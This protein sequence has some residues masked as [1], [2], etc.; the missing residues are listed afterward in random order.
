MKIKLLTHCDL[1]GY[2]CQVLA[3]LAFGENVEVW[4]C[5]YHNIDKSV[6]KS[7]DDDSY[8]ELHITDISCSMFVASQ[9]NNAK[10]KPTYLMDHH[11]TA[12]SL[13]KFDWCQVETNN[14]QGLLT[15]GTELYYHFLKEKGYLQTDETLGK[16]IE[17]FVEIVRDYDTWRWFELKKVQ[18][19]QLND[20]VGLYGP[21]KFV[22]W[23]LRKINDGSFPEFDETDKLVLSIRQDE[24]DAYVRVKEKQMVERE[25]LE[26]KC[27]IVFAERFFDEVGNKICSNNPE[28]DLIIMVDMAK[29]K[30]SY[31]T[32]KDDVNVAEFA[33]MI[34]YGGGHPKAAGSQ[35][36]EDY[37]NLFLNNILSEN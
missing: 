16:T 19:K 28:I 5:N 31:R 24:I 7:I 29:R 23:C 6:L 35:I 26:R 10:T 34:A 21:E 8:D 17:A 37:I 9:V 27:G 4:N 13:N 30:V 14:S 20:L 33:S 3:K 1:D 11:G 2:G 18:C 36:H 15:C 25:I 12:L 32:V 22:D